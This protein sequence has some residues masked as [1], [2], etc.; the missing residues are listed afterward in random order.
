MAKHLRDIVEVYP[1]KPED[2]KRFVAKHGFDQATGRWPLYK[3]MF[4]KAEYDALFRG[5]KVKAIDRAKHNHGYN[6]GDDEKHYE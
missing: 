6:P 3:N 2:E 5:T 1:P 4:A